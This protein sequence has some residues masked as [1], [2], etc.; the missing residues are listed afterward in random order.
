MY[1]FMQSTYVYCNNFTVRLTALPRISRFYGKAQNP[2]G[3]MKSETV[4]FLYHH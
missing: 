4:F 3:K 1:F 2:R